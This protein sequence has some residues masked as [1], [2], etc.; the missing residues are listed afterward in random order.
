VRLGRVAGAGGALWALIEDGQAYAIDGDRFD[1]PARGAPLG[2][3]EQLRWLRPLE[4]HNKVV[5]LLSNW[6]SKDDRDGPSF[7]IKPPTTLIDPG[8][9]IVYPECGTRVVYE[10][11][12][13]VV[14]G[15]RARAI[16]IGEVRDHVLGYTCFNDVTAFE[17]SLATNFSFLPGK[18]FDTFGIAG[19]S[20]STDLDPDDTPLRA[21]VNGQVITDTHTSRMLWSTVEIVSWISIFLTLEPG[22]LISCGSPPEYGPIEPGDVVEIEIEGIGKLQNPVVGAKELIND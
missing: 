3:V 5:C 15:K 19:P 22:D 7:F 2:P 21:S 8:E 16:G 10:P 6:R 14:I 11:E 17:M 1:G 4:P 12:I 18:S 13:A 9:A 20:I